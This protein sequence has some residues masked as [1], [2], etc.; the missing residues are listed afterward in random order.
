MRMGEILGPIKK[1][2][3]SEKKEQKNSEEEMS[4]FGKKQAEQITVS[5]S[6]ELKEAVKR[7]EQN[8]EVTGN[9]A[10]KLSWMAK[11]SP[12]KITA[13]M[14]VLATVGMTVPLTG[15]ASVAALAPSIV[16]I[17][18]AETANLV[19][20]CSISAGLIIALYKDYNVEFDL[21]RKTINLTK[22]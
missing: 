15:G 1:L 4:V 5:S 16:A 20:T 19:L 18:G 12:K 3:R 10:K 2:E 8:I 21:V 14:G 22:K 11:L 9:L 7:K 13:I 6:K 17:T